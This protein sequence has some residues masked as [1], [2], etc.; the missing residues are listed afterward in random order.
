MPPRGQLD[1]FLATGRRVRYHLQVSSS[2]GPCSP[3]C[4]GSFFSSVLVRVFPAVADV[5]RLLIS[6]SQN[7]T[8]KI[9]LSLSL[10]LQAPLASPLCIAKRL[11]W[12]WMCSGSHRCEE[13]WPFASPPSSMGLH[14]FHNG[15]SNSLKSHPGPVSSFFSAF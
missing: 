12:R 1:V 15:R 3:G 7:W 4:P 8:W 2:S 11:S 14:H 6:H 9:K 13:C 10:W 5:W